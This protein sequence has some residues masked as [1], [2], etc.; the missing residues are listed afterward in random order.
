M[1]SLRFA[2]WISKSAPYH[3]LLLSDPT[4]TALVFAFLVS[5]TKNSVGMW[6]RK[7]AVPEAVRAE[8][9][10]RIE[11]TKATINPDDLLVHVEC[12]PSWTFG[13]SL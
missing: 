10:E 7:L 3:E 5:K 12:V 6:L 9:Y 4:Q 13:P 1:S 11:A 8:N 2:Y